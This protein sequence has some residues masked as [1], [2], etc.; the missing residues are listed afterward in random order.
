[1]VDQPRL[2]RGGCHCGNVR[3]EFGTSRD[4]AELSPRVC[5]CSF[6]TK[7]GASYVSDPHGSLSI[8]ARGLDVLSEYR[9]GAEIARFLVCRCCG[10][11]IAVV[12]DDAAGIY[13]T[14]NARCLEDAVEFGPAQVVSPRRFSAEEKRRRWAKL[15]T[16]GVKLVVSGG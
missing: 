12:F 13:G 2:L 15:W 10:V 5:D 3:I 7:H 6:C 11:L 9:H 4:P 14:L 1:M 8:E 16:P